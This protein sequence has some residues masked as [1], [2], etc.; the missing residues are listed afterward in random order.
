MAERP[1]QD[2]VVIRRGPRWGRIASS[3]ALGVLL[4][5]VAVI[6]VVWIERRPIAT[7]V[8]KGE[9]E[10]RGVAATYHLDR[11]GL[12]T[13][14]VHDL[15]IGDP[16]ASRPHGASRN[17]PDALA[18]ERQLR[19]LSGLCPRRAAA[20]APGAR[21]GQLGPDRQAASAA[22]QQALPAAQFR[23]GRRAT[24]RLRWRPRSARSEWR[25]RATACSAAASRVMP[26]SSARG[27]CPGRCAA[28]NL[29]TNVAVA[30]VAR[31]PQIEGPVTL[32]SFMCPASRLAVIT[33]QVRCQG[34]LQRVLHHARRQ[35][36]NGDQHHDRRRQRP[37]RLCRR[38]DLQGTADRRARPGEACGPA[39]ADGH[40]LRRPHPPRWRLSAR[41]SRRHL[42]HGRRFRRRQRGA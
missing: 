26:R 15:I 5:L 7:H 17:H 32:D 33:P 4:L 24:P 35:R 2:R 42:C 20:R 36:A 1:N 14:E 27:W 29:R 34:E 25:S 30:V 23:L 13:Q 18:V 22:E 16:T 40:H 41:H 6:A 11:V 38:A 19:G 12:R 10:R 39:V 8:L 37:G 28:N 9:F 21:Q 31:R 3:V